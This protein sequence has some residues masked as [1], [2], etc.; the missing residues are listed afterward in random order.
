MVGTNLNTLHGSSHLFFIIILWSLIII[1]IFLRKVEARRLSCLSTV[2]QTTVGWV[3]F[4]PRACV[5]HHCAEFLPVKLVSYLSLPFLRLVLLV[6]LLANL[7]P[8]R[9]LKWEKDCR[10]YSIKLIVLKLRKLRPCPKPHSQ[11]C[12]KPRLGPRGALAHQSADIIEPWTSSPLC[13]K[14]WLVLWRAEKK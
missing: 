2:T 6:P 7:N 9:I 1:S 10:V 12:V 4:D 3:W 13:W 14:A 5:L 11:I 8:K